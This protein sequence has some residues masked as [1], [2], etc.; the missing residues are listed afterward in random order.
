MPQYDDTF[1]DSPIF[2]R[3]AK[4]YSVLKQDVPK[5]KTFQIT[6]TPLLLA[7]TNRARC[8]LSSSTST[9]NLKAPLISHY[10][11]HVLKPFTVNRIID[12]TCEHK[13]PTPETRGKAKRELKRRVLLSVTAHG[14]RATSRP[15][16]DQKPISVNRR[17]ESLLNPAFYEGLADVVAVPL[18]FM[19]ESEST[20]KPTDLLC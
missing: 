11:L 6:A 13:H 18:L 16:H 10:H 7:V 3:R 8:S 2:R 17:R 9:C 12:K 1:L 5:S 4:S 19:S 15:P 14:V 20:S